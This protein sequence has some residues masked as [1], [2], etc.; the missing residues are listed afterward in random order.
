MF[1]A[2]IMHHMGHR[3]CSAAAGGKYIANIGRLDALS[4]TILV[5][6]IHILDKSFL[7]LA[8]Y[9]SLEGLSSKTFVVIRKN[10]ILNLC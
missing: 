2:R 8:Y 5:S 10:S 1:V 7:F 4:A 9:P 6:A 3:V